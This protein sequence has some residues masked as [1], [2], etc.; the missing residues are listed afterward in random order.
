MYFTCRQNLSVLK[1][2]YTME[3][4]S[5]C[6]SVCLWRKKPP[7]KVLLHTVVSLVQAPLSSSHSHDTC[8]TLVRW[9]LYTK[10][11]SF[12]VVVFPSSLKCKWP[13]VI[14]IPF[15]YITADHAHVHI[16]S[17]KCLRRKVAARR[18]L[19]QLPPQLDD[20]STLE[21]VNRRCTQGVGLDLIIFYNTSLLI[22]LNGSQT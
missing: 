18:M 1:H 15:S 9:S 19:K 11:P 12:Y 5:L 7:T 13:T 14:H 6:V 8:A 21:A 20:K 10:R 2:M 22:P 4:F 16:Q 17:K 3:L